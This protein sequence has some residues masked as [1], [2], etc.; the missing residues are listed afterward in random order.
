LTKESK[1]RTLL[2][3]KIQVSGILILIACI[4]TGCGKSMKDVAGEDSGNSEIKVSRTED[5]VTVNIDTTLISPSREINGRYE[6]EE[7]D[8]TL[9]SDW[10]FIPSI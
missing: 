9:D 6:T 1:P 10:F 2:S 4:L 5:T 3:I 7:Y 8:K